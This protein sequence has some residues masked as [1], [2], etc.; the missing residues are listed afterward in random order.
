MEKN[1]E[2]ATT[3]VLTVLGIPVGYILNQMHHVWIWVARVDWDKY[4]ESDWKIT[5]AF[6]NQKDDKTGEQLRNRYRYLLTRTHE[7]GG[8]Y[9]A[10][11]IVLIIGMINMVTYKAYNKYFVIYLAVLV[12][13]T[14][15]IYLSRNY[16]RGNLDA[17]TKKLVGEDYKTV[18]DMFWFVKHFFK[19]LKRFLAN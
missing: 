8:I 7:L 11:F 17:F 2:I 13:I 18:R 16:Y 19:Q 6:L 4:F 9:F 10:L 14:I 5:K 1:S 3:V 12:V 15:F